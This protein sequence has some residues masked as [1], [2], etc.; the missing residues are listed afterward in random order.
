MDEWLK[1]V[2]PSTT[3]R[4]WYGHDASRFAEFQ[5]RYREE[6]SEREPAAALQHLCDLVRHNTVT[7]VTATRDIDISQAA[8]LADLLRHRC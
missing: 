6:L 5:C 7:L 1:Q 3:L 2:A 4:Q 8:V